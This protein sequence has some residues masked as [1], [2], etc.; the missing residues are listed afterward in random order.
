M[1][2]IFPTYEQPTIETR[3][4]MKKEFPKKHKKMKRLKRIV[5][6][7]EF[8]EGYLKKENEIIRIPKQ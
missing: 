6:E 7:L 5:K 1:D 3:R 8:L 2:N 4:E